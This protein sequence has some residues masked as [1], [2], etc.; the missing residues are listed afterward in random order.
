M[1]HGV[2]FG[3]G[4]SLL[5]PGVVTYGQR[6]RCGFEFEFELRVSQRQAIKTQIIIEESAVDFFV[7]RSGHKGINQSSPG[8]RYSFPRED[9]CLTWR[10]VLLPKHSTTKS[11][12]RDERACLACCLILVLLRDTK[13]RETF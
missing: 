6:H 5:V 2:R 3:L 7:K 10:S 4:L 1:I 12:H 13:A 9:C 8:T 11:E